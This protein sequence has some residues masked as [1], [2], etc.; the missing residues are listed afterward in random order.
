MKRR[1]NELEDR[2]E[3]LEEAV[4]S[5]LRIYRH[6][7]ISLESLTEQLNSIPEIPRT[8]GGVT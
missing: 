7:S 3:K 1:P 2:I 4:L 5:L 6:L 8:D